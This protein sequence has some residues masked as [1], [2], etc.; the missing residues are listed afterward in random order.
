VCVA[1][2]DDFEQELA[3]AIDDEFNPNKIFAYQ[4]ASFMADIGLP[5]ALLVN[6]LTQM[7]TQI[8]QVLDEVIATLPA[9]DKDDQV[10][11]NTYK[12]GLLARCKR[13]LAIASEVKGIEL[14]C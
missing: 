13:Y 11:V 7:A 9:L 3:M 4:L 10:F 12:D 2:Y 5:S 6:N 8:N 14:S 1:L